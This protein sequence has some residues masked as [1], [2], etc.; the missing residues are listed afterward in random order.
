MHLRYSFL[1]FFTTI[2]YMITTEETDYYMSKANEFK[3]FCQYAKITDI[4]HQ[5]SATTHNLNS[6]CMPRKKTEILL[7]DE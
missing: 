6:V 4:V 7:Y 3:S 1:S 5:P 2:I